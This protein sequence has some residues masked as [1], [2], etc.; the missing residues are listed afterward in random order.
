[1][2]EIIKYRSFEITREDAPF[3]LDFYY[4]YQHKNFDDVGLPRHGWCKT[5]EE[6]KEEID[7]WYY[8]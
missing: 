6:C 3:S 1:M 5:I 2:S 8:R 7:D 4:V